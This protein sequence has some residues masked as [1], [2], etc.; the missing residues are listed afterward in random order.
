MR[1]LASTIRN[2]AVLQFRAGFYF[3]GAAVALFYVGLLRLIPDDWPVNLGLLIPAA[4]T[5]NVMVTTY[6]FVAGLV[7]FEKS[8]QTLPAIAVTPLRVGEYLGSKVA[9][10]TVLALAENAIILLLVFGVGFEPALLI[11]GLVLLCAIYTLAGLVTI[12]RYESINSFLIPSVFVITALLLPLLTH[13]GAVESMIMYLHPV[14]PALSLISAAFL[15]AGR[16]EIIYGFVGSLV[17]LGIA[18]V[19]ARRAFDTMAV[20]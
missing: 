2:D 1:R 8:E 3:V 15:P 14:Q 17:W 18:Y 10:L 4:L 9:S 6:Y 20:R 19:L 13:F 11:S 12:S 7:L 16:A 5:I